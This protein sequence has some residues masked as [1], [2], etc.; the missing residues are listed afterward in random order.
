MGCLVTILLVCLIGAV[1]S[2]ILVLF[3]KGLFWVLVGVIGIVVFVVG[4]LLWLDI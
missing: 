3:L 1:G 2:G 4:L